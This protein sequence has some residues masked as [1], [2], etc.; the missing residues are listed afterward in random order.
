M[1]TTVTWGMRY[2]EGHGTSHGTAM[3]TSLR[4]LAGAFGPA[5]FTAWMEL[6]SDGATGVGMIGGLNVSFRGLTGLSLVYL[7]VV[8][9]GICRPGRKQA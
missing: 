4:T 9:F 3:L 6:A 8:I 2:V 5:V 7:L 1:M